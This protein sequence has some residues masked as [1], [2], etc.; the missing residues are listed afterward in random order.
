MDYQFY[1]S[2]GVVVIISICLWI[3]ADRAFPEDN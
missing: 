2:I 3:V 1:L